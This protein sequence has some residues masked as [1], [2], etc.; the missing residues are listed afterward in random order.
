MLE[1]FG[2]VIVRV[3]TFLL[4]FCLRAG[5]GIGRASSVRGWS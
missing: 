3:P 2:P 1:R 5:A 4:A